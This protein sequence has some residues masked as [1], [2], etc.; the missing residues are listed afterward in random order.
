MFQSHT[1]VPHLVSV[2]ALEWDSSHQILF[3][4]G[5]F[6]MIDDAHIPGGLCMWTA[7]TGLVPFEGTET[8]LGL[9][10]GLP[11][12]EVMSLAYESQS[13]V[14][15]FL[16]PSPLILPVAV[17]CW[18]ILLREWLSMYLDCSLEQVNIAYDIS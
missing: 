2:S 18:R 3:I 12:G 10:P 9:S 1:Y 8:G 16:H 5:R 11:N 15:C 4:G 14:T 17:C 13:Q 6:D 7:A